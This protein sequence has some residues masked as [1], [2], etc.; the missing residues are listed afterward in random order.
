MIMAAGTVC[1]YLV[2]GQMEE[3]AVKI[4]KGKYILSGKVSVLHQRKIS[5]TL[6]RLIPRESK[7]I[8]VFDTDAADTEHTLYENLNML[9]RENI[10]TVLI[11]QVNNFEDEII[12]ATSIKNIKELLNSKSNSDFKSD[13]LKEKN[14]L[15]KLEDKDFD[16]YKFWSRTAD[17][18]SS[19]SKYEN[20]SNK[21]KKL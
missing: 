7:V 16:I 15:K 20:R 3:K 9:Q 19:F 12:Y 5:N 4:L 1:F 17:K 8:I 11:P 13:F 10:E 21:I 2:E 14:C 6:L 18:S